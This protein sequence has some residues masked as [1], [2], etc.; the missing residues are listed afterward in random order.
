MHKTISVVL[1]MPSLLSLSIAAPLG[2]GSELDKHESNNN[3]G[4]RS[5]G[6]NPKFDFKFD[7]NLS[8][9]ASKS[10]FKR[11]I[12][13]IPSGAWSNS[14]PAPETL[15][16]KL[17]R[18]GVRS[19]TNRLEGVPVEAL[20]REHLTET[21]GSPAVAG[22]KERISMTEEVASATREGLFTDAEHNELLHWIYSTAE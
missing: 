20:A 15:L 21:Y 6:S 11:A 8:R 3:G 17:T 14:G 16:E 10:N 19:T 4:H 13:V 2:Q 5:P 7:P 22:P 12:R 18:N 1:L 9:L